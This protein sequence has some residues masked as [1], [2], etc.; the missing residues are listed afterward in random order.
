LSHSEPIYTSDLADIQWERLE[1]LL[2]LTHTGP[3]R[4]IELDV[5]QAMNAIFYVLRTGCQWD[6]MPKEYPNHNS[7][8]YH[9]RK[10]RKNQTWPK[11]NEA[12]RHEERQGREP[13]P[14]AAIIDSHS[15]KAPKSAA[16]W[17]M[18]RQES[19]RPQTADRRRNPGPSH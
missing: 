2:G 9:Y 7:V 14:S 16:K 8:Y 17:A 3:G 10:W 15:V 13:E 6:E 1:P 12:L 18:I 19:Q 11:V 5:R 4:P